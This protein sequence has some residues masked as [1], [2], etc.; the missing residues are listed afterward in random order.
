MDTIK[1]QILGITETY[2][3]WIKPQK[4]LLLADRYKM[5]QVEKSNAGFRVGKN[6]N[7]L[8]QMQ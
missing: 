2:F 1:G 4:F 6:V 3:T 5:N 7:K 8:T